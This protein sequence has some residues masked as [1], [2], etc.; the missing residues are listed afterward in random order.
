[1]GET[2]SKTTKRNG[3]NDEKIGIEIGL[4]KIAP[5]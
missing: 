3:G 2:D 1:M 5:V 4:K